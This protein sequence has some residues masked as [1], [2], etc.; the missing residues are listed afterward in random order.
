VPARQTRCS[1]SGFSCWPKQLLDPIRVLLPPELDEKRRQEDQDHVQAMD[2]GMATATYRNKVAVVGDTRL[3]MMDGKRALAGPGTSAGL[4]KAAVPYPDPFAMA[5]EEPSIEPVPCVAALAEAPRRYRA[6]P[7]HW[8]HRCLCRWPATGDSAIVWAV[9]SLHLR[10]LLPTKSRPEQTM[11][12]YERAGGCAMHSRG[13]EHGE[14]QPN[15]GSHPFCDQ[16]TP[17]LTRRRR[18]I[19]DPYSA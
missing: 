17:M 15:P 1:C 2:A 10:G 19:R 12:F 13:S 3:P 5:T 4:A 14:L 8:H 16:A 11:C 7:A 9:T 18:R 6:V